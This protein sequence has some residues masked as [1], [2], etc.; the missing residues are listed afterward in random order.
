[1]KITKILLIITIL[2]VS[3]KTWA[4][5]HFMK[6]NNGCLLWVNQS[7]KAQWSGKCLNGKANGRGTI[8]Y[9]LSK[10][11]YKYFGN[12]KNGVRNGNGTMTDPSGTRYS[13]QWR[14]GKR[15]GKGTYID[16]TGWRY[17]GQW[18]NDKRHGFG[19]KVYSD[20]SRYSG[21]WKN[22]HPLSQQPRK[23]TVKQTTS[24][25]NNNNEE[26]RRRKQNI[27]NR[28]INSCESMI[29]ALKSQTD[30][31][32]GSLSYKNKSVWSYSP[33]IK[34]KRDASSSRSK[35]LRKCEYS[36]Y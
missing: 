17:S 2:I 22:D 16:S 27:R 7:M 36:C 6:D 19:T 33:A 20:G 18:R 26:E 4:G 9:S 14:N 13:G 10:Y 1:M 21:Q 25:Y 29:S 3:G 35:A 8:I 31:Y 30:A 23:N 15:H 28:C 24:S 11:K 5:Y 32:C 12:V 34:C